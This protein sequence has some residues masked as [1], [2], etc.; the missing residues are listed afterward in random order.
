VIGCGL[1]RWDTAVGCGARDSAIGC[2]AFA[3]GR[4]AGGCEAAIGCLAVAAGC[5]ADG[6]GAVGGCG[7]GAGFAPGSGLARGSGLKSWAPRAHAASVLVASSSALRRSFIAATLQKAVQTHAYTASSYV[8]HLKTFP[9]PRPSGGG[10]T[11]REAAVWGRPCGAVDRLRR[12]GWRHLLAIETKVC[13]DLRE[14]MD[15]RGGT[16]LV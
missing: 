5:G 11:R 4:A 9:N 16:R 3:A 2:L 13:W 10:A 6:C 8:A 14:G 15:S 12:S 7:G 1:G